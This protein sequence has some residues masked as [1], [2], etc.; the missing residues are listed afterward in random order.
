MLVSFANW[1]C[2]VHITDVCEL[3]F[4]VYPAVKER[5]A[6]SGVS[7]PVHMWCGIEWNRD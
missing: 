1:Y 6:Y 2:L 4:N 5:T 3:L 7:S